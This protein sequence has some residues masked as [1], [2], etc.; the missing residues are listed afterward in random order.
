MFI[1]LLLFSPHDIAVSLFFGC[2]KGNEKTLV[3]HLLKSYMTMLFP[4]HMGL[5]CGWQFC[6]VT[7]KLKSKICS[8]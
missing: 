2:K 5:Q 7:N 6:K 4:L 8:G 3:A 1:K